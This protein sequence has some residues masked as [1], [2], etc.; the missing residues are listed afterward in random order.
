MAVSQSAACG[1]SGAVK[2][3]IRIV[4]EGRDGARE[5]GTLTHG[6]LTLC[7]KSPAFVNH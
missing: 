7:A 1:W 5:Y 6:P 3:P 2:T 4:Y